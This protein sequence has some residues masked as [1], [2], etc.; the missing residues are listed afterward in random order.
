M[1]YFTPD[2]LERLAS[3]DGDVADDANKEWDRAIVLAKR[4]WQKI[5]TAFP[6][7]AQNFEHQGVCL[8][9][10]QVLSMAR[11]GDTLVVV[12]RQEPPSQDM[13]LLSF[14]LDAEPVIDPDAVLGHGDGSV[15]TWL[16]EEWDLDRQGRC[17]FEVLLSNAWSV[18]FRFRDF[19]FLV[20]PQ[21]LPAQNGRLREKPVT[22]AP[23]PA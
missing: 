15:I 16:D 12:L 23:Q 22:V 10:A 14:T 18:R 8:H 21:F 6:E 9:D 7:A 19:Q 20:L 1:N 11:K 17:W 13:V 4:R 5:K 3:S 2:L